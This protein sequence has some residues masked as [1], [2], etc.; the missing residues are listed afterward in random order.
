[1]R[2]APACRTF[3]S[4]A[5]EVRIEVVVTLFSRWTTQTESNFGH[6]VFAERPRSSPTVRKHI[7]QHVRYLDVLLSLSNQWLKRTIDTT[8]KYFNEVCKPL[9]CSRW[10]RYDA[11]VCRPR[12]LHSLLL[13][14]SLLSGFVILEIKYGQI[15]LFKV[16]PPTESLVRSLSLIVCLWQSASDLGQSSYQ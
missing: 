5:V 10:H 8:V 13:A 7:S 3:N 6:E 9:L 4:S 11:K 16:M 1:M 2:P 12:I 15:V 14:T